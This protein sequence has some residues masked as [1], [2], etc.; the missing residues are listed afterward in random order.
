MADPITMMLLPL[1][2]AAGGGLIGGIGSAIGGNGW[3]GSYANINTGYEDNPV[4]QALMSQYGNANAGFASAGANMSNLLNQG[5]GASRQYDPTAFWKDFMAAQPELQGLISGQTG[6]VKNAMM[7][8]LADFTKEAVAGA[9]SEMSGLGS[10][11]SGAFGDIVGQRVGAEAAKSN[12]DLSTLLANLYGSLGG[13]LMGQFA[14]GRQFQTQNLVNAL[15]SGAGLYGSQQGTYGSLMGSML[16]SA[17]DLASPLYEYQPGILDSIMSGLG[18]GANLG[19]S[20]GMLGSK[21]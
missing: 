3:N 5:I 21:K 9:G 4:Y 13:N 16:G 12:V 19:S 18:L 11:Y 8:N 10:L 1:L 15:M 20:I 2:G 6:S 14:G 7:T 17:A